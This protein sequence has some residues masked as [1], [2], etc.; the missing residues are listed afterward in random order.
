MAWP[1]SPTDKEIFIQFLEPN[2]PTNNHG[3]LKI[4]FFSFYSSELKSLGQVLRVLL[5]IQGGGHRS[6]VITD[7]RYRNTLGNM[8]LISQANGEYR[9]SIL[10]NDILE[11]CVEN[12]IDISLFNDSN[13]VV[14]VEIEKKILI[15]LVTQLIY[16]DPNNVCTPTFK[17]ILLNAQEV[18][19]AIPASARDSVVEDEGKLYFLQLIN[20]TG[21]EI[22]RFYRLTL[23]KQNAG[24]KLWQSCADSSNFPTEP[25]TGL[26]DSIVYKYCRAKAKKTVQ[27]DIRF[28]IQAFLK[29]YHYCSI[30]FG[31]DMPILDEN[32]VNY[33][34]R[35]KNIMSHTI[36]TNFELDS[37]DAGLSVDI[38]R[39]R[40]ISG[41]P[42]TG[43]SR[44]IEEEANLIPNSKI[45]KTSFH[46]ETT[47]FDFVGT[48]KPTPLYEKNENIVDTSGS[49]FELGKPVINY[50]FVY[51]HLL[52][53]YL[54]A[55]KNP[56]WNIILIIDEINRGKF[57]G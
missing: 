55:N 23:E 40:I 10:G 38:P 11:Y 52:E 39:H 34:N 44:Y 9:P 20:A 3:L 13:R 16:E 27:Y 36:D 49:K 56:N 15:Y 33:N 1:L 37:I 50:S 14:A 42:G 28:R 31:N 21:D 46:Q 51:G 7:V 6:D 29:A 18:Y 12:E 47:Y 41:W 30:Q 24:E 45:I 26:I 57:F 48:Y 32:L 53:S 25:P 5:E 35:K 22:K 2:P 8:G 4:R 54:L 19:K 43:K 17:Q